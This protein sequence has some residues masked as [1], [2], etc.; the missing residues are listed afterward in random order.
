MKKF[1]LKIVKKL[2]ELGYDR[3]EVLFFFV[4]DNFGKVNILIG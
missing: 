1:F 4:K 2:L 3:M